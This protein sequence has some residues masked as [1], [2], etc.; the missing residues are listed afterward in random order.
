MAFIR[1]V[2]DRATVFPAHFVLLSLSREQLRSHLRPGIQLDAIVGA[3]R[4]D[5]CPRWRIMPQ[6]AKL[7]D[8][9]AS[10]HRGLTRAE[11]V[12]LFGKVG[13]SFLVPDMSPSREIGF[14]QCIDAL[15]WVQE[16]AHVLASMS[17]FHDLP[18]GPTL[19]A[20]VAREFF[21]WRLGGE[22][23]DPSADHRRWYTEDSSSCVLF[24]A[25]G[26]D[27]FRPS[28]VVKH[29][30]L[31]SAFVAV[32]DEEKRRPLVAAGLESETWDERT[33][34]L[35]GVASESPRDFCLALL[36]VLQRGDQWW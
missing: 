19:D 1:F 7:E 2:D 27:A 31:V 28:S 12:D 36:S 26:E 18:S 8:V 13:R 6:D 23:T 24:T 10:T 17:R 32:M 3:A 29:A 11:G 35:A 21:R 9:S 4:P 5:L 34:R 14:D 20:M 33:L 30:Q 15:E 25:D 22:S 16:R